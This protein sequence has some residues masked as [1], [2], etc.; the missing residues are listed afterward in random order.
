MAIRQI[1]IQL[2]ASLIYKQKHFLQIQLLV[3]NWLHFQLLKRLNKSLWY[4]ELQK[5]EKS[6]QH[7]LTSQEWNL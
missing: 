4:L 7:K 3:I 1:S 5:T 6:C 2:K